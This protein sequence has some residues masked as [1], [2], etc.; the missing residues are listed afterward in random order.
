[1]IVVSSITCTYTLVPIANER[2]FAGIGAC[3]SADLPETTKRKALFGW[4]HFWCYASVL[5]LTAFARVLSA[6]LVTRTFV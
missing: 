3:V 6:F 1:M 5:V 4:T 2:A